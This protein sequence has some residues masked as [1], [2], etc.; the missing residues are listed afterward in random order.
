M[1]VEIVGRKDHAHAQQFGGLGQVVQISGTLVSG[2]VGDD[3]HGGQ[4]QATHQFDGLLDALAGHH[5]GGL[6]HKVHIVGDTQHLAHLGRHLVGRRRGMVKVHH[7][8]DHHRGNPGPPG[9][10]SGG[11]GVDGDMDKAVQGG[12]EGGSQEVIC[13]R[14]HEARALPVEI[15]VMPHGGDAGF[16][17]KL[18]KGQPQGNI[19]G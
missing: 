9:Q 7:V 11:E 17:D 14:R 16:G 18:G 2:S 8:G 19:H 13:R 6:Q 3:E 12:R 4:F 5:A 15:V 1:V 10:L